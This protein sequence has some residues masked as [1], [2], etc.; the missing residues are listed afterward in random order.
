VRP[1]LLAAIERARA[2]GRGVE[3]KN[4]PVCLLGAEGATVFNGQPNLFIDPS[5]WQEFM[6]N[7][8]HQCVYQD[9][10]AA[11]EC[12]GL[13]TAYILKYGLETDLLHPLAEDPR[14]LSP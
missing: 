4:F 14:A 1:Y 11:T 9:R 6:R 2:L 3:V 12:L 7:G 13:N 10:C 8:F 5:F